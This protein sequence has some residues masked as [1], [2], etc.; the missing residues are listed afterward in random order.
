[1]PL[2]N[3]CCKV[4]ITDN[5]DYSEYFDEELNKIN[6][7]LR[8][9]ETNV[10][11]QNKE[12]TKINFVVK[13][14]REK[15]PRFD[16]EILPTNE[17]DLDIDDL[18]VHLVTRGENIGKRR[19]F[20]EN[21]ICELSGESRL[22]LKK[23]KMSLS[24]FTQY[25]DS[26]NKKKLFTVMATRDILENRTVLKSLMHKNKLIKD[27]DYIKQFIET[28]DEVV[29][30]D[31]TPEN[32]FERLN[33]LYS[34]LDEQIITEVDEF[35]SYITVKNKSLEGYNEFLKTLGNFAELTEEMTEKWAMK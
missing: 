24:D 33:L 4:Q 3:T 23:Q 12:S 27:N 31:T 25:S 10:L 32:K 17:D 8:D 29:T 21:G 5:F 11:N 35:I 30:D 26:L 19:L 7:S 14:V 1:M 22:E 16:K 18:N 13:N 28:L 15:I 2:D 6:K 9:L 20:N 34:S